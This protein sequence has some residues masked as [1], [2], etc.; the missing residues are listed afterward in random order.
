MPFSHGAYNPE[1]LAIMTR[2][3]DD[4]CAELRSE[5]GDDGHAARMM[6]SLRI[7]TTVAAGERDPQ[8]L[9]LVALNAVDGR[10]ID[11]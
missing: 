9:R 5:N 7:M 3:V 1:T 11:G 2:A 10:S 6:M 4:A 8:R